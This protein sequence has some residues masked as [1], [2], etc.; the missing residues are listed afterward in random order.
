LTATADK[1]ARTDIETQLALHLRQLWIR[2]L[3]FA[4]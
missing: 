2:A 4:G 1:S 3:V